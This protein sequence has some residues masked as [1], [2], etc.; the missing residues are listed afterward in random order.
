MITPTRKTNTAAHRWIPAKLRMFV[1]LWSKTT[2]SFRKDTS[3]ASNNISIA[4][5]KEA[6]Q[7]RSKITVSG[8][9]QAAG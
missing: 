5:A 3:Q 8:R 9:R 4:L 7:G 2:L 1:S 6:R